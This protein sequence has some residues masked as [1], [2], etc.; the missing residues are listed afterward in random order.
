[1]NTIHSV[2]AKFFL[3]F[4]CF[5][6]ITN[7]AREDEMEENLTQV[8]GMLGN[9]RNMAIDMGSEIESQNRQVDRINNKVSVAAL[10]TECIKTCLYPCMTVIYIMVQFN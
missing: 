3:Y 6:R 4:F 8:S 1:M 7:D 9:L 2:H 5:D 10:G